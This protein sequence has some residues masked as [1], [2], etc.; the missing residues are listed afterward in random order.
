MSLSDSHGH[1]A[2]SN[3][4]SL[5]KRSFSTEKTPAKSSSTA[6]QLSARDEGMEITAEAVIDEI[7][8]QPMQPKDKIASVLLGLMAAMVVP[9]CCVLDDIR[10]CAVPCGI[11]NSFLCVYFHFYVHRTHAHANKQMRTYA[12]IR[13][14]HAVILI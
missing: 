13:E 12:D 10:A 6:V 4:I 14:R 9:V 11:S 5:V 2:P 1:H 8:Y 3:K 7:G